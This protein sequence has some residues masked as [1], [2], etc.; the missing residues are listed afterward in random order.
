M[1]ETE[2]ACN[3]QALPAALEHFALF[4]MK[5]TFAEW[6]PFLLLCFIKCYLAAIFKVD[7]RGRSRRS[8]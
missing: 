6:W 4:R 8:R 1:S 2:K 3:W 7:C 5:A